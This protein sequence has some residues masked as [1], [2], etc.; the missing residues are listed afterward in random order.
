[1]EDTSEY[2][3]AIRD[4]AKI[5]PPSG[6]RS[7]FEK[8]TQ[9]FYDGSYDR[10]ESCGHLRDNSDDEF[11]YFYLR[12]KELCVTLQVATQLSGEW[13]EGFFQY[14][15]EYIMW[16]VLHNGQRPF[17]SIK[18]K[19]DAGFADSVLLFQ[20]AIRKY[21]PHCPKFQ[22]KAI[23]SG[24]AY[25]EVQRERSSTPIAIFTSRCK[26]HCISV[27]SASSASIGVGFYKKTKARE[28][29][30]I[31]A[32]IDG[33][34]N[35]AKH[36]QSGI[37][38]KVNTLLHNSASMYMYPGESDVLEDS[39]MSTSTKVTREWSTTTPSAAAAGIHKLPT[40]TIAPYL[41][42]EGV[43]NGTLDFGED[44]TSTE[45]SP[46]SCDDSPRT[47]P[48]RPLHPAK[49][50]VLNKPLPP[51]RR[52]RLKPILKKPRPGRVMNSLYDSMIDGTKFTELNKSANVP[53]FRTI[54][55]ENF[56]L[57]HI[58]LKQSSSKHPSIF[59]HSS[60]KPLKSMQVGKYGT[61]DQ[62]ILMPLD[63]TKAANEESPW[64]L[65]KSMQV[66]KIGGEPEEEERYFHTCDLSELK[67]W[68]S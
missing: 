10:T 41:L 5:H 46:P 57:H 30:A 13:G 38:N 18:P 54:F 66:E 33:L 49:L 1:M 61:P 42:H 63:E 65:R 4:I 39:G 2:R 51:D 62:Q 15:L 17:P 22:E 12:T 23:L 28:E 21:S 36:E 59:Q 37:K 24:S 7:V 34:S 68:W 52:R 11:I 48:R 56:H 60:S 47:P 20:D 31:Q 32:I 25:K 55:Y 8:I 53:P 9:A 35:P 58:H 19:Q 40:Q 6:Y 29:A 67:E 50:D 16:S 26:Y 44:A 3:S 43:K 14:T 64:E 27:E 45:P